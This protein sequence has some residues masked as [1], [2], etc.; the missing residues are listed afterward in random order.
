MMNYKQKYYKYKKEYL[1]LKL[2]N[3]QNLAG[4]AKKSK[5]NK[6]SNTKNDDETHQLKLK[7]VSK[8][9][10]NDLLKDLKY[11]E[12]KRLSRMPSTKEVLKV[13]KLNQFTKDHRA[14]KRNLSRYMKPKDVKYYESKYGMNPSKAITKFYELAQYF[15]RSNIFY[16]LFNHY[17]NYGLDFISNSVLFDSHNSQIIYA[18]DLMGIFRFQTNSGQIYEITAVNVGIAGNYRGIRSI[19]WTWLYNP[20]QIYELNS[21]MQNIK[22][23]PIL[24]RSTGL[25][26]NTSTMIN[27]EPGSMVPEE[28]FYMM[29]VGYF[30][31]GLGYFVT[32]DYSGR[33]T[34]AYWII[35]SLR[36]IR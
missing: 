3:E 30:M 13:D 4:G 15:G 10:I 11:S 22:E 32:H 2:K 24:G 1:S 31:N 18:D 6:K 23:N 16:E 21:I 36:Q 28:W 12:P 29:I 17:V 19:I 33:G 26:I 34:S 9:E 5:N 7:L 14:L 20:N 35:T 27:F 8:K 25:T